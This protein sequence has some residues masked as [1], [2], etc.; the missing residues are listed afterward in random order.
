[1]R[2]HFLHLS[3]L[4]S[5]LAAFQFGCA[6]Q[7]ATGTEASTTGSPAGTSVSAPYQDYVGRYR[8]ENADFEYATI[9]IE[10]GR[11]YG[12]AEGQERNELVPETTADQFNVPALN[13]KVSFVRNAQD[14]V[15]GLN[16]ITDEGSV[17]GQKVQ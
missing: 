3:L 15:T 11:L 7:P 9:T 16:I 8:V 14:Q 5:C 4:F 17:T 1:M 13:V 2:K 12:Q 6:P 10:E